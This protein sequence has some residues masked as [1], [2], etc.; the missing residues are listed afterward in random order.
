MKTSVQNISN[1]KPCPLVGTD[2]SKLY[3]SFSTNQI[4]NRNEIH[5][6]DAATI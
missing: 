2:G 5:V 4:E 6:N 3:L 1:T